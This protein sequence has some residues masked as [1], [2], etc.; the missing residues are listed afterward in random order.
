[1]DPYDAEREPRSA[2]KREWEL[3]SLMDFVSRTCFEVFG[4]AMTPDDDFFSLGVSSI[5]IASV[6]TRLA[7]R[8]DVDIPFRIMLEA[9]NIHGL[10]DGL[11]EFLAVSNAGLARITPRKNS[12]SQ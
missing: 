1:V 7:S 6:R 2:M 9:P 8:L 11:L 4:I 3:A 10:C 5:Q 12:L